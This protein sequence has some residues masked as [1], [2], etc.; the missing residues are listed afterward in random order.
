MGAFESYKMIVKFVLGGNG[1]P[2]GLYPEDGGAYVFLGRAEHRFIPT[3]KSR[4]QHDGIDCLV[5]IIGVSNNG[6]TRFCQVI[7]GPDKVQ[8]EREKRRK[9]EEAE[10]EKRRKKARAELDAVLKKLGGTVRSRKT[11]IAVGDREYTVYADPSR[12]TREEIVIPKVGRIP[13]FRGTVTIDGPGLDPLQD[14]LG[15]VIVENIIFSGELETS[16][17]T[18]H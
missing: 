18:I 7:G 9:T 16:A 12:A 17:A 1:Q 3:P 4:N 14:F 15:R 2:F 13:T 10:R 11:E 6:T 8:F 5:M